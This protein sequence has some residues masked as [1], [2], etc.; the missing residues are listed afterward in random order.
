MSFPFV[1]QRQR[2]EGLPAP[3]DELMLRFAP[4]LVSCLRTPCCR[5]SKGASLLAGRE[6]SRRE[7]KGAGRE[8]R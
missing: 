6:G 7:G 3:G 4:W 5:V 8:G 1:M 2:E